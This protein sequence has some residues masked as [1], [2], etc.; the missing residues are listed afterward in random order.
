MLVRAAD[1]HF[2]MLPGPG[3]QRSAG[4]E[5]DRHTGERFSVEFKV[6]RSRGPAVQRRAG[7]QL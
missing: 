3:R 2:F 6:N 7:I 4:A 5:A 1:R